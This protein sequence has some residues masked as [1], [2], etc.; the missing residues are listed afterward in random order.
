[1]TVIRIQEK[2]ILLVLSVFHEGDVPKRGSI[3]M[4]KAAAVNN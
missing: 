1:L 3:L 4:Q 2:T